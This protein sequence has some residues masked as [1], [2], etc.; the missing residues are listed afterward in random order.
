M[1]CAPD[2]TPGTFIAWLDCCG[3]HTT[4][5]LIERDIWTIEQVAAL[6]ADEVDELKYQEGCI[7]MD[8]VWEHARTIVG[9]LR[10]RNVEGGVET[11]LQSRVLQLRKKRE[12]EREREK[13][14]KDRAEIHQS[15]EKLLQQHREAIAA[16]KEALRKKL[17]EKQRLA[18]AAAGAGAGAGATTTPLGTARENAS[19]SL[20]STPPDS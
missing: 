19:A 9:P 6:N 4:K 5:K 12:L 1:E 14:L 10:Q 7:K 8:V 13:L 2:V 15:R 20:H 11:E 18:A 16:K 3:T 17:E